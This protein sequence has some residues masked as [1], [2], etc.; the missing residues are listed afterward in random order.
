MCGIVGILGTEGGRRR[1]RRRAAAARISRLRLGRRRHRRE[2]PSRSPARRGQAQEPG[3]AALQPSPAGP[4]RPRPHALGDARQAGRAQRASAHERARRR[5]AQRHHRELPGAA[6]RAHRQGP[7][8]PD[9]DRHRDG[10]APRQRL[11]GSGPRAGRGGQGRPAAAARRVRARHHLRR[12]G[13]PDDRRAAGT[14][15]RHRARRGRDVSRLG[16]HRARPLHRH[17]H[18]SRGRRLGGADAARRRRSSTL[19]G[20]K[21][22]RPAIKSVASSLLVDKGNYRHFMAKEIHE[23]PEVISHT[24]GSFI[25]FADGRVHLPDLGI[26][27]A[28][29]SKVS[30]SAC[31]TAYY[32]GL[33][34]KYWLERYARIPVEIDVASEFRYRE[35]PLAKGGLSAVH[36]AVG[37]DGRYAGDAAL[38]QGARPAHRLDRQRAH[39]HHRARVRR[40]AADAGRA[41]DRRR[42]DQGLHLP[43]HACWPAWRSRSAARAAPSAR[44]RRRS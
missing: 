5:R 42:L 7:R 19:D 38:L 23:Q 40:R 32:A 36:L 10:A 13:Q 31:G 2:R 25:D 28:S 4:H 8:V 20:R 33:V 9:R 21:V 43:A 6:R 39:L 27:P 24:L 16:R 26:D 29:I 1:S 37:R 12:R 11:S 41:R 44:P 14:A 34:G 18:L 3:A 22:E 35:P 30:I 15:A 17:D